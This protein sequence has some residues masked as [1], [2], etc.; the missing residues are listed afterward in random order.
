[1]DELLRERLPMQSPGVPCLH[2]LSGT[3]ERPVRDPAALQRENQGY[4]WSAIDP[5]LTDKIYLP[6]G[7]SRVLALCVFLLGVAVKILPEPFMQADHVGTAY[8]TPQE[9]TLGDRV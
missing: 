8:E 5:W 2:A 3:G 7:H 1:M 6:Y 4:F 9:R